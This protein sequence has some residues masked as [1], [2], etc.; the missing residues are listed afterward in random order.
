MIGRRRVAARSFHFMRAQF[1][2]YAS[3]HILLDKA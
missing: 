3:A 2:S 1:K